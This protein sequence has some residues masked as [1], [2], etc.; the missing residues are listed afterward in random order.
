MIEF[1][2]HREVQSAV[3]LEGCENVNREEL[4]IHSSSCFGFSKLIFKIIKTKFLAE[5]TVLKL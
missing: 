2:R 5:R 1:L 4:D 3:K